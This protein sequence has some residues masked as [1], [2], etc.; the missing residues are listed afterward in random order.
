MLRG[1]HFQNPPFAQG[2]LVRVVSGAVNDV[3]VDIRKN[4]TTF[5]KHLVV[6]LDER[7]R[8]MLWV[9][10]G[11]AHGFVALEDQT[12][13]LYKVSN[14]YSKESEGGIIWND[15]DLSINWGIESPLVSEKDLLLG[16]LRELQTAF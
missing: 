5:G 7:N 15:P 9:P 3:I 12:V 10:P 1:L 4:S 6:R 2:K 8:H 11:F 16:K 13:F 14:V